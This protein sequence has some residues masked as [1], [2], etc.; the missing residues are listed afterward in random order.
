MVVG[1]IGA[2]RDSEIIIIG[3]TEDNTCQKPADLPYFGFW[4]SGGYANGNPM[5]AGGGDSTDCYSYSFDVDSWT[6]EEPLLTVREGAQSVVL[7]DGTLWITGGRDSSN[8]QSTTELRSKEGVTAGRSLPYRTAFHC[9]VNLNET[10]VFL[11]GGMSDV[12]DRYENRSFILN[13]ETE[14][15]TELP[16]MNMDRYG[17]TCALLPN[18]P[19]VMVI[20]GYSHDQ[21][22]KIS[23]TSTTEIFDFSP[24]HVRFETSFTNV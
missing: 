1:G 9:L 14:I 15:W 20:G 18:P 22:G 16:E 3:G 13:L 19:R 4:V 2:E 8:L 12:P 5:V 6:E 24:V 10:H 21:T 11:G 17:H 23:S 7:E